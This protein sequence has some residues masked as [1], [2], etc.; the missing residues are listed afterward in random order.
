[1]GRNEVRKK[2]GLGEKGKGEVATQILSNPN[3][4]LNIT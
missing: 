1:V 3:T 4:T 2:E